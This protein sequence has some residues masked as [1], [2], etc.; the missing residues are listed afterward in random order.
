MTHY[1]EA[2]ISIDQYKMGWTGQ[3]NQLKWK[4][5]AAIVISPKMVMNNQK[6]RMIGARSGALP[7]DLDGLI[8][9]AQLK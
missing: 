1:E 8:L 5:A 3:F 4:P 9:P 6:A 2:K 7:G